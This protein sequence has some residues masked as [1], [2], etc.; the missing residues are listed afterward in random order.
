[1]RWYG[2]YVFCEFLVSFYVYRP[3]FDVC[4]R[5]I[6]AQVVVISKI[7]HR[8][9]GA[10]TKSAATIGANVVQ[11]FLNALFA[12]STLISANHGFR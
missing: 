4:G 2:L 7:V 1:M 10:W 3:V 6:F 9:N 11:D 5:R 8:P 12:E